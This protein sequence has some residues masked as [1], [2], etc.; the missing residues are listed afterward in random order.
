MD[1]LGGFILGS[2]ST[3]AAAAV[4]LCCARRKQVAVIKCSR[5]EARELLDCFDGCVEKIVAKHLEKKE[6]A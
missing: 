5:T 6:T 3:L 4:I 1:W 2:I